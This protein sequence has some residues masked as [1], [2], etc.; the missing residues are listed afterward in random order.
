MF[1]HLPGP[2]EFN[3]IDRLYPFADVTF[4]L[5]IHTYDGFAFIIHSRDRANLDILKS[6][7]MVAEMSRNS[8]SIIYSDYK[9]SR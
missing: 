5:C 9:W 1:K 3:V 4:M 6:L 7:D 8:R 2:Y